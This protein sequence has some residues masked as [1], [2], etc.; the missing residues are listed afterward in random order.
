LMPMSAYS[1]ED[2]V[3]D[4]ATKSLGITDYK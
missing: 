3:L 2:A 1:V 4:E